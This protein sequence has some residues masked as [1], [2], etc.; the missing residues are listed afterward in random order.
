MSLSNSMV[1]G[2]SAMALGAHLG[3]LCLIATANEKE[4]V[5]AAPPPT[6][7]SSENLVEQPGRRRVGGFAER[8]AGETFGPSE[9]GCG[10][11]QK[12]DEAA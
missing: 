12:E 6:K 4:P 9:R 2:V 7:S 11:P 3:C 5:K 8:L 10:I 1:V